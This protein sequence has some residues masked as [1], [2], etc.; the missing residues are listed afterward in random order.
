[1]QLAR[2]RV[3]AHSWTAG[4]WLLPSAL[5]LV[6]LCSLPVLTAERSVLT[7]D[8]SLYLSEALNIETGKGLT[9]TTGRPI[10]HRPPLYPALLAAEFKA[11]GRS[12][13]TASWLPRLAVVANAVLVLLLARSILGD[14]AG[15]VAGIV[16]A[17]SP[18]LTGL[19]T[20]LFLDGVETTFVLGAVLVYWTAYRSSRPRDYLAAG[21][22]LGLAV[23]VK[24]SAL[25]FLP[26]ALVHPLLAGRT[27]GWR[28]GLAWWTAG[29]LI[30]AGWWW[31]WVFWQTDAIFQVGAWSS[32]TTR[33]LVLGAAITT[34]VGTVA[35]A[36]LRPGSSPR[37]S[38][39]TRTA[40][41]FCL[42][43]WGGIFLVGLEW[44]SWPYPR[45]YLAHVP[46]Y[47]GGVIGPA[48]P[49][50]FLIGGAW[51]WVLSR[52]VRGDRA[53]ALL[54][55]AAALFLPFAI[56][57]ANRS[58][59]LRDLVPLIYLSYAALGAGA[60]WLAGWGERLAKAQRAPGLR[61]AGVIAIAAM[62]ALIAV[63]GVGRVD[64]V[65]AA[66]LDADWDN[67]LARAAAAWLDANLPAGTPVMSTRLYYSHLYFLTS[68]KFPIHQAPTVLVDPHLDAAEPLTRVS[69]LFRWEDLLPAQSGD[70][71]LYLARYPVKGYYIGLSEDDLLADL[72]DRDIGYM[73]VSLTDAG[74]SSPSL[75]AYFEANHA[76]RLV[77]SRGATERD[78]V[79]IYQV[80][81]DALGPQPAPLQ[82]TRAAYEGLLSAARGDV[83][84]LDDAL[85]RLNPSGFSV[86]PE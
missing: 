43:L 17:A 35:L 2:L 1:M 68:G 64:R 81:R 48:V 24:E 25:L 52:S 66:S 13:D 63:Q 84:T 51:L 83:A 30:V 34:A 79:R 39:G 53:A 27:R 77:Y 76:F 28:S 23:L 72:K 26:L 7:S 19:G 57:V 56:F 11:A 80:D 54:A 32:A 4:R 42:A 8:E 46:A 36:R 82:V 50:A 41:A 78:L 40:A 85:R 67:G 65:P 49:P 31:V 20:T 45:D 86:T 29:F 16:A 14:I 10:T 6:L 47:V 21:A 5:L 9:Y 55:V 15:A 38:A 18:Y 58:L 12:L 74:F 37:P 69:T 22:L 60:V 3:R 75:L 70:R 73:V 71:W 59:S 62:T 44:R 33:Q 61:T